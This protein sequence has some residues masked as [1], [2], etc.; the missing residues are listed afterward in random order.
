MPTYPHKVYSK[1]L[2]QQVGIAQ[3]RSTCAVPMS[4]PSFWS[5]DVFRT[6]ALTFL[7]DDFHFRESPLFRESLH[8]DC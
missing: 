6:V 5:K 7:S 2:V 8:A 4:Y 3:L 1:M